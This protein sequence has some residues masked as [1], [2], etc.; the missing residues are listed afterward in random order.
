MNIILR[1]LFKILRQPLFGYIHVISQ[2]FHLFTEKKKRI[3]LFVSFFFFNQ[4]DGELWSA[5]FYFF[6]FR[7]FYFQKI[8]INNPNGHP[9]MVI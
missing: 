8:E 9:V 5:V 1:E 6:L 2:D 4:H 7:V 3:V